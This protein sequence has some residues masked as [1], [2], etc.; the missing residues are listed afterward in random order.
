MSTMRAHPRSRGEHR[1][2]QHRTTRRSGSS[3]LTRG[4]PMPGYETPTLTRLIPAHAG[5]TLTMMFS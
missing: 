5:S 2:R 3:P 1:P 4:A